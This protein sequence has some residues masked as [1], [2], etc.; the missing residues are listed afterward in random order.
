MDTSLIYTSL[1]TGLRAEDFLLGVP[2]A[3]NLLLRRLSCG[4]EADAGCV[5]TC[6]RSSKQ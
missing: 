6:V 5:A 3:V 2:V 4:M 1:L